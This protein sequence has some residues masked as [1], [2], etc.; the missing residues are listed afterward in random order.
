[1]A[2]FKLLRSALCCR[3]SVAVLASLAG[4]ATAFAQ[5]AP[6]GAP[7][8]G[9]PAAEAEAAS[10]PAAAAE[11]VVTGSR[12]V[13]NGFRAP[14][15]VTVLNADALLAK[16][17]TNIADT[18]N[19]LPQFSSS[20]TP[21]SQPN[22]VSGGTIG[23][24][25]LNLR[26]LG[27]ARTLVLLDGRRIVN[28]SINPANAAPDIN[29]IPSALVTRV[30]VV[31]GGASAAY[32]SDALSGVVN[33]VLDHRFTGVKGEA[34]GGITTY[35]DNGSFRASLTAGGKFGPDGRGHVI[36]SGEASYVDGVR[37]NTRPWNAGGGSVF[38]N[39]A[40]TATNG[41]PFYL[42]G[43]QI[44]LSNGTPGGLITRGPLRGVQ[45]GPGGT[46]T[47]FTFGLVST[48]N[49]MQGGDW[50]TSR[51]DNKID[52]AAQE[53]IRNA[54]SR[55]SYDL[56]DGVTAFAEFQY[57]YSRNRTTSTPNRNLDNVTIRSDN[58]F[59]PAGVASRLAALNLTSFVLGTTNGDL[60]QIR[61]ESVRVLRR[62]TGG[63]E[64]RF[65]LLGSTW[66]W[67]ASYQTSSNTIDQ[68]LFNNVILA[69]YALAADAVRSPATGAIVCRSTLT[70]PGNGC[71]PYNTMGTGVNGQ[72]AIDYITGTG[73]RHQRLEQTVAQANLSGEPFA[74]WAGPVS[75]AAGIE[76]RR[77]GVKDRA[78]ALDVARAFNAGNYLPTFGSYR[79]TEG[80]LE[81]VVP[82][83]R[84]L[85]WARVLEVNAA[86]RQTDY[87][88]SGQVTTWKLGGIY[89]PISDIRFR[90]TRSR[91]IRAPFLGDLFNAGVAQANRA[92]NDPVTRTTASVT[93]LSTGNPGLKP[94][95]AD[96]IGAGVVLSPA[97]VPRLQV[98]VD[99]YKVKIAGAI[100]VPTA[101][102]VVDLCFAG[103][104]ALCP[105]VQRT[106]GVI[107]TV[108]TAPANVQSQDAEGLDLEVNYS[109]PL[110]A[111]NAGWQGTLALRA[112]GTYV[113]SLKNFDNTGVT[114]GAGVTGGYGSD[115]NSGPSAPKFRSLVALV[116]SDDRLTLNATWNHIAA[117]VYNNAFTQCLAACPTGSQR[118][119]DSNRVRGAD[120]FDA[121]I[122]YR[123]LG[124]AT[125]FLAA[126]NVFNQA[127]PFVGGSTATT[128]SVGQM[129][130]NF[131][132]IGRTVKAGI[133]FRY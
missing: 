95:V 62:V 10:E 51:I 49:V 115:V 85:S 17:D 15:P 11:V 125:A 28:S 41:Q 29:T 9:E 2:T 65:R 110:S 98:S 33:F 104:Q 130:Y 34:Q 117:G 77:E 14:T 93:G 16:A 38:T 54:Y 118:T 40:W 3:A 44:G 7:A 47:T 103:N 42:V 84:E 122:A 86:V 22:N 75:L 52:I 106:N 59:I 63:L 73:F 46:P 111:L 80:Y 105:F 101:Q 53:L 4:A 79:V 31:T 57:A 13:R 24:N 18:I 1:M 26:A 6:A 83:A 48:N 116:Y 96:T 99:Y 36:V 90:V 5:P 23:V 133:R 68:R 129:N 124:G 30:D 69:N 89:A 25:Q 112:Y 123:L 121:S 21:T 113:I 20:V 32:G 87:S 39:P 114:Q 76:H 50:R 128:F 19:E 127:P 88:T 97:F 27:P 82:L 58:P 91:D 60:P 119:I 108:I 109:Q 78:S 102:S 45:F 66:K 43:G 37:G 71:V 64:G 131:D 107:T 70:A 12:V 92:V 67:D 61:P 94:E 126:D 55:V 120:T 74:T 56:F 132:R 100:K 72:A 35:G 8:A 81:T